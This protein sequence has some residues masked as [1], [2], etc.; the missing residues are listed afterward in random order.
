MRPE[1]FT[2]EGAIYLRHAGEDL[3]LHNDYDFVGL[4]YEVRDRTLD[5]RWTR[6]TGDWVRAGLPAALRLSCRG[7]THFW[8]P[9]ETPRCRSPRTIVSRICPSRC[10]TIRTTAH[11]PCHQQPMHSMTRGT[12]SSRSC[13]AFHC[14]SLVRARILP[15]TEPNQAMQLTASKHAV[16]AWS[17]CRWERMLRGMHGGLAAAD[18]VSR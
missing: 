12:G 15:R 8:L 16:H 3:D 14:E 13:L 5:L 10:P 11:S 18:L 9:C 17:V 4:S 6:S 7:V 1:N 2:T